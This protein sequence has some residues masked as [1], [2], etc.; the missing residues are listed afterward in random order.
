M[1][2]RDTM[3]PEGAGWPSVRLGL[4]PNQSVVTQGTYHVCRL[5]PRP[6]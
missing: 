5:S 6:H 4:Y 3:W 2:P 1:S